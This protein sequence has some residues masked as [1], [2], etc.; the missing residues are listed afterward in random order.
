MKDKELYV[1]FEP[2]EYKK[3]KSNILNS[4]VGLLNI[5]KILQ[6]LKKLRSGESVFKIQMGKIFSD[7]LKSLDNI[8]EKIPTPDISKSIKKEFDEKRG[9][10]DEFNTEVDEEKTKS[11]DQELQNIQERLAYLNAKF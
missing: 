7:V 8:E 11:I 5:V 4:Q 1:S 6:R 3:N 9:F 10:E 2:D